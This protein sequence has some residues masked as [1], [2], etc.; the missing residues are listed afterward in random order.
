M[1]RA[2]FPEDIARPVCGLVRVADRP[3]LTLGSILTRRLLGA[4][5][6]PG[7]MDLIIAKSWYDPRINGG[8]RTEQTRRLQ[9]RWGL[10]QE[11]DSASAGLAGH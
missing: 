1:T 4:A 2:R 5:Q 7:F 8:S 3:A 10:L 9:K 6:L 11:A